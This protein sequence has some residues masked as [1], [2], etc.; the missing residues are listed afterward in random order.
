MQICVALVNFIT[1]CSMLIAL[2]LLTANTITL[3]YVNYNVCNLENLSRTGGKDLGRWMDGW[4]ELAVFGAVSKVRARGP[5]RAA[6]DGYGG[7]LS[8]G[9]GSKYG[10]AGADIA[11]EPHAGQSSFPLLFYLTP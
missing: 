4:M 1:Y 2:H 7:G 9:R 6:L 5:A 3:H 11:G 8:H 10:R